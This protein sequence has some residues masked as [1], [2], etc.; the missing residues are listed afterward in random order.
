M[1]TRQAKKIPQLG[2]VHN[3]LPTF[4]FGLGWVLRD[5]VTGFE[6]VVIYRCDNITGCN[7]Y[8]LA[9]NKKKH[10]TETKHIDEGRLSFTGET[11]SLP[12]TAEEVKANPG[13]IAGIPSSRLAR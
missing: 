7:Q 12:I 4:K 5:E 9:P 1:A 8:G 13:G 11:I 2:N 6:G 10:N 3:R